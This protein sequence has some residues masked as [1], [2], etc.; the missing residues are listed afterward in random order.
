MYA[1]H[2]LQL[3]QVYVYMFTRLGKEHNIMKNAFAVNIISINLK[4]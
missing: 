1:H 4:S 3:Y 2:D